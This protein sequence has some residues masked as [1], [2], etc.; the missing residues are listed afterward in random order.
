MNT[1]IKE[2]ERVV[3]MINEDNLKKWQREL[4]I[5]VA[6]NIIKEDLQKHIV[7]DG[8]YQDDTKELLYKAADWIKEQT[9]NHILTIVPFKQ[10][11]TKNAIKIIKKY[12]S[13][14]VKYFILDT[15]KMDAGD[16]SDKSWL[17]MQQNMVEINDVIKPESKNLHILIV[18]L[19]VLFPEAPR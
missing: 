18:Y 2:K 13:M 14:G 19:S 9:Q 6:N 1:A 4:L 3:A 8:H 15:F 16:V 7:R 12:S 5:F 11:K 17:E 10:Y